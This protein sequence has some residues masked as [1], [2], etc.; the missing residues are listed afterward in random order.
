[1]ELKDIVA[2]VLAAQDDPY[3][4]LGVPGKAT[5]EQIK[6][7]H[8]SLASLLHP[9]RCPGDLGAAAAMAKV[10]VAYNTLS[11]PKKRKRDAL[12]HGRGPKTCTTCDG[13][14][15]VSKAKGFKITKKPC[16]ACD[17][18]GKV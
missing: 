10:N 18:T 13:T 2:G 3:K 17:G 1:M 11:D 6:A 16:A 14:G 9:D 7:A 5:P 12:V 8:R 15:K 4:V